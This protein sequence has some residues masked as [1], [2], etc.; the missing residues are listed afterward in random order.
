MTNININFLRSEQLRLTGQAKKDRRIFKYVSLAT[1]GVFL[2]FGTILSVNQFL[3]FRIG[4]VENQIE[5]ISKEI[6]N[7]E[8]L[9]GEY[10]FFVDK[11][12]IIR[13]LFELRT[14]KQKAIEFFKNLFADDVEIS[15]I[16]YDIENGI[17]SLQVNNPHV[18]RLE[19]SLEV[20]KDPEVTKHFK[21]FDVEA[22][23]RNR[24]AEYGFKITVTLK[25]DSELL[26][27]RE[28]F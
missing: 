15:G 23:R 1:A 24:E 19:D 21:T 17:L 22:L 26:T 2:I 27:P 16:N 18:F 12:K 10:L 7:Q 11:L 3:T 14:D 8:K 4:Q 28:S 25:K 20:L 9:E 5:S 6:K 13:K